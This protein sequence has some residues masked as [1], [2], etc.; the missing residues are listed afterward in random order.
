MYMPPLAEHEEATVAAVCGRNPDT[1]AAFADRWGI[2]ERFHDPM[3]MLDSVELDAVIVAS[4]NDSHHPI[5][6]AALDRGLHVLCEKP[7]AQN[8]DQAAEM[9]E[10][11]VAT[12][13]I[14][15]ARRM[16]A[17]LLPVFTIRQPDGAFA[18]ML[19]EPLSLA[20]EGPRAE[21]VAATARGFA[22]RLE[23]PALGWPE[24]PMGSL[25]VD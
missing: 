19:D 9:T 4:G 3:A 2:A 20:P 6:I 11:A 13:A 15:L 25:Q 17:P 18:V 21:A 24:Q 23:P 5:T 8:A 22:A 12:G 16:G 7:L 1:T 14:T 10:R